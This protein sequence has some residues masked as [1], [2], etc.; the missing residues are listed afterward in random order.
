MFLSLVCVFHLD[1][2]VLFLC[3]IKPCVNV[4]SAYLVQKQELLAGECAKQLMRS[5]K[6]MKKEEVDRDV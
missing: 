5:T 4:I 2:E 1:S 6:N 3:R